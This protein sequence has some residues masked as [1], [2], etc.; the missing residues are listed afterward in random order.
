MGTGGV[1]RATK[2]ALVKRYSDLRHWSLRSSFISSPSCSTDFPPSRPLCTASSL[3]TSFSSARGLFFGGP[4]TS[5]IFAFEARSLFLAL[6][7]FV[8]SCLFYFFASDN[9][10]HTFI[11]YYNAFIQ[12]IKS[13]LISY[14]AN[15]TLRSRLYFLCQPPFMELFPF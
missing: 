5:S 14:L 3:A 4:G 9:E 8:P 7:F 10:K 12:T 13:L 2:V 1:W 6:P 11:Y 15:L